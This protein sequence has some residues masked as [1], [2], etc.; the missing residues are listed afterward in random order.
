M[1]DF[2]ERLRAHP[3]H[4]R[5]RIA[6]GTAVGVTAIIFIV[7][8]VGTA[9]SGVLALDLNSPTAVGASGDTGNTAA[10]AGATQTK[11]TSHL[12]QLLGAIG[13]LQQPSKPALQPVDSSPA[14]AQNTQTQ[15][16]ENA[17]DQTT[18]QF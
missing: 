18:L 10:V 6:V 17:T 7:W 4:I 8:A 13:A 3:V 5:Q 11:S 2:I 12:N 9:T 1:R 16:N 14:P 15:T